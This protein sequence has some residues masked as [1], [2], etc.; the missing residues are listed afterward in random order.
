MKGFL[1]VLRFLYT[2]MLHLYPKGFRLQFADEM[3]AVFGASIDDA[4]KRSLSALLA[5]VFRELR[6]GSAL[7]LQE[8]WGDFQ[9]RMHV[10]MRLHF[11]RGQNSQAIDQGSMNMT[12]SDRLWK[13]FGGDR[14]LAAAAAMPPLLFGMGVA[15]D[16]LIRGG[17]WNTVPT[18]RL[19]LGIGVGLFPMLIIALVGLY[20]LSKRMPVWGL[21]WIGSGFM[22]LLLLVKTASEELADIDRYIISQS[23]DIVLVVL[24]LAAGFIILSYASANG[25]RRAGLFSI[26]MST[27]FCL[28]LYL[29]I[30][31]APFYRHDLALI[32]APVGLLLASLTYGYVIGSERT[33]IL[34][35]LG[36]A[37]LNLSPVLITNQVWSDW[38][39]REHRQPVVLPLMVL[40]ILTLV[41]G[42]VMGVILSPIT[43]MINRAS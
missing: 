36:I 38:L 15:V 2:L 33:R 9:D 30:T 29:S 40:L 17:P 26:G 37:V 39:Q 35:F 28:S 10:S 22:G 21:T 34:S 7:V 16:S 13:S 23:A 12:E 3:A 14:R 4:S 11:D 24:I 41:S 20:A 42:P 1:R 32:S 18:W 31:S 25:W 6:D 27:V 8:G 5:C 19:F 43:K